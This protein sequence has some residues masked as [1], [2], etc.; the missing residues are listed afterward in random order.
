VNECLVQ[1]LSDLPAG[2][3]YRLVFTSCTGARGVPLGASL[4]LP[5]PSIG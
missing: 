4:G 2:G 3:A 1:V 5:A